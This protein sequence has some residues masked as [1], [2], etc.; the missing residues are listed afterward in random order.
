MSWAGRGEGGRGK[1][2]GGSQS[3]TQREAWSTKTARDRSDNTLSEGRVR[4]MN[5]KD[6][7]KYR[8]RGLNTMSLSNPWRVKHRAAKKGVKN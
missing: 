2:G 7:R 3:E 4:K 1:G 5:Q 8:G 6:R